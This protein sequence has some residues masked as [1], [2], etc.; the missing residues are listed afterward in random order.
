MLR[1]NYTRSELIHYLKS[2]I[3]SRA[4]EYHHPTLT[5]HDVKM[6]IEALE[7]KM[8]EPQERSERE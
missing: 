6:I 7:A 3:S 1:L 5:V 2:Y 4:Y 8:V